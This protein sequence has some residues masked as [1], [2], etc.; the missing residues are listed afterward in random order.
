MYDGAPHVTLASVSAAPGDGL[1]VVATL[2]RAALDAEEGRA[3]APVPVAAAEVRTVFE[4]AQR[5]RV[6]PLLR[7]HAAVLG[8]PDELVGLLDRWLTAARR[9]TMLQALETVRAWE[10]LDGAGIEVLAVKGQ[11]LAVQTAGRADARG[12]GDVDLLVDPARLVE[13]HRLLTGAGWRLRDDARVEPDTWAWRH[14]TRWGNALTYQ[15]EA[16]DVDL[17]WRLDVM[18]DAHPPFAVLRSRAEHVRVGT[19]T[20]A[21][22]SRYD[23]LRHLATHREGWIWLRTLVDLRRL[24]RTEAALDGPLRPAAALSLAVARTTVGLPATVP[25]AVHAR[26]DEA[27]REVVDRVARLHADAVPTAH[28]AVYG[29]RRK[30]RGRLAELTSVADLQHAAVELVLPAD[31]VF[32]V[33][34]RTGWT[35]VPRALGLR[36][37]D[38]SRRVRRDAP[39]A[40]PPEPAA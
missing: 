9:Q 32:P 23:A 2:V 19:A 20:L 6:Q 5:H 29:G 18:P 36:A 7:T 1:G 11:A 34:S 15:G 31:V 16:A 25:A 21:T 40:P 38:L 26:L 28:A 27:P 10:L 37:A 39:C 4:V 13:A 17:H 35:G 3:G 24:A 30:L 22:L 33:R 12:P 8:L 14:L